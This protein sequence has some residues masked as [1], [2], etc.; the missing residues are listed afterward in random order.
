MR[1]SSKE[2]EEEGEKRLAILITVRQLNA[3]ITKS[4]AKMQPFV[5]NANVE[6]F[7]RLL[8]VIYSRNI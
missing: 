1:N 5:S 4:L 8:Q 2:E 7:L 3:A 6:E